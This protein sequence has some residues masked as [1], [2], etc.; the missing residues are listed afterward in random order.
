MDVDKRVEKCLE[1][2]YI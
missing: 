2:S 1:I